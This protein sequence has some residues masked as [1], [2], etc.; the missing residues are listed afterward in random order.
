[1]PKQLACPKC[2]G[3]MY[4]HNN[5]HEPVFRCLNCGLYVDVI[6]KD[7]IPNVKSNHI[8]QRREDD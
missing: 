3:F 4:V 6:Y 5:Y 2:R 1:M 8:I 7:G